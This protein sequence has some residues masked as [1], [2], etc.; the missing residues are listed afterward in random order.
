MVGAPSPPLSRC[1]AAWVSS[2]WASATLRSANCS[3]SAICWATVITFAWSGV[4]SSVAVVPTHG[5]RAVVL[6]LDLALIDR[7]HADI[8]ENGFR[9]LGVVVAFTDHDHVDAVVRQDEAAGTGGNRDLR[10]YR[11]LPAWKPAKT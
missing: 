4:S 2:S 1:S 11:P 10:R 3:R 7:Q 5:L 8:V 6:L 9:D